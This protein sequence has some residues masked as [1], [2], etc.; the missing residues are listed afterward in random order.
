MTKAATDKIYS[1]IFSTL[2]F[3]ILL[4]QLFGSN[5]NLDSISE[6]FLWRLPLIRNFNA[7]RYAVGDKVF[8]NGLVGR[9]GWLYYSGDFSINDYQKTALMGPN[10]LKSLAEILISLNESVTRNG[11]VLWV[12]IPPDKNTIYPQYMPEQIPVIGQTSRLDQI[13]DYLQKNTEV[14]IL[15]LRPVFAHASQSS[16]IY[17]KTD[18]HWNCLGA[19]YASNEII[20][21]ITALHPEVQTH[22]LSNF[23]IG[24]TTDSTLDILTAM[25]LG[26]QEDTVTLTPKFP[27]G[28]MTYV[29]YAKNK[30]MNVA[31]NSQTDL[32]RAV[33]LHDSF[34]TECL[35]QFLEPQFSQ[36][37]STHYKT[38]VLPDYV[39]LIDS[40]KPD[41]VIVEFAERQMEYFFKVVTNGKE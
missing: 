15:D 12:I 2:F 17:Y 33:V 31:V 4:L 10:R 29:P 1:A 8:N 24:S 37:I 25:G 21:K 39:E 22:P 13:T 14:N 36:I 27:I 19:Y 23:Q 16:Q 26:S 3:A 40:E 7:F 30:L 34:Y 18:A 28:T 35:Y 11:G 9:D 41:V 6:R 20:S 38:A 32:P 5:L